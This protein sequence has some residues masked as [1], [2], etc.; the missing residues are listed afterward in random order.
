M[1]EPFFESLLCT[2]LSLCLWK[3]KYDYFFGWST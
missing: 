3:T 2:S 1:E